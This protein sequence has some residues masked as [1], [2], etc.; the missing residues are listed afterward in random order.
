MEFAQGLFESLKIFIQHILESSGAYTPLYYILIFIVASL[1][2]LP[3][4][5]FLSICSGALWGITQG[6]IYTVLAYNVA[7]IITFLVSRFISREKAKRTTYRFDG[8]EMTKINLGIEQHGYIYV[9]S[10]RV[11]PVI[12]VQL[13]NYFFGISTIKFKDYLLGTLVGSI[14]LCLIYNCLGHYGKNL[15]DYLSYFKFLL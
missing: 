2:F 15:P 8:D 7:A 3:V 11:M 5:G 9:V 6:T 1:F 14:P 13:L 10:A 4:I 12:P